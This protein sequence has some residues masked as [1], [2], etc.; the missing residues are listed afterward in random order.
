VPLGAPLVHVADARPH[1]DEQRL[2][3]AVGLADERTIDQ[4]PLYALRLLV[5]IATRALS[6]AVNDPTTAIQTLD[7]IEDI[8]R[9]V[10]VRRLDRGTIRDT[11]GHVRLVVPMPGWEDYLAVALTEIRQY[12]G[13]STQVVRRLRAILDDLFRD[14]PP[15]RRPAVDGQLA[16]LDRTIASCFPDATE[17]ALALVADR[18]GI[19]EPSA[20]RDT[21]SVAAAEAVDVGEPP[22]ASSHLV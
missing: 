17:R 21:A 2:Q 19:G 18:H 7:R 6:P 4:D 15:T 22:D 16:L 11:E 9:R 14:A 12:G 13:T 3:R 5:D 20:S 8:L 1:L 10:A